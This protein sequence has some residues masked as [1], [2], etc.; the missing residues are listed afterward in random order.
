MPALPDPTP[1]SRA[2][3]AGPDQRYRQY[4]PCRQLAPYVLCYWSMRADADS[5][6]AT[7]VRVVPDGCLDAVFDP[8][9][10][11]APVGMQPSAPGVFLTGIMQRSAVIGFAAP[12]AV[13]GIRF[14]PAGTGAFLDI[15]VQETTGL[16]LNICDVMPDLS[17]RLED[18]LLAAPHG[19]Q[20]VIRH[21][22]Q[23]LL[24]RLAGVKSSPPL[25]HAAV[26]AFAQSH[27]SLGVGSVAMR[28]GVSPRHLER[29]FA[30]HVGLSPKQFCRIMRLHHALH[31]LRSAP[32]TPRWCHLAAETGFADQAHLIREMRTLFGATP[33][34]LQNEHNDVAFIQYDMPDLR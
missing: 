6:D 13:F 2:L 20:A 10:I 34:E 31:M 23:A 9:G 18:T 7:R 29:C 15:H 4:A 3:R 27:G 32:D 11:L 14:R 30:R 17:A 33:T 12:G 21:M 22:E 1:A 19:M 8:H 28:L 16:R 24:H 25:A 26:A 5:R